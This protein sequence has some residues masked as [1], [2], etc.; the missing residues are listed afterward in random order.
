MSDDVTIPRKA[1]KDI[2]NRLRIHGAGRHRVD[3]QPDLR[4]YE[5]AD[6]LDPPPLSL[7]DEVLLAIDPTNGGGWE[8]EADAVLAV[9]RKPE[10]R[11][12]VLALL[13]GDR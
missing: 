13:G 2:A 10:H 9:L 4:Y 1:A 6:L 5:L 11:D 7:R 3:G 8:G 12:E